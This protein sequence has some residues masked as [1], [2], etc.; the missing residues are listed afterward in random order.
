MQEIKQ[1][2][3]KHDTAPQNWLHLRVYSET[4]QNI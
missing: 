3:L 4:L 2:L 1:V